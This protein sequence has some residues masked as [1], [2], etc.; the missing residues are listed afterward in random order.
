MGIEAP[1]QTERLCVQ[2]D[3]KMFAWSQA[4]NEK[5]IVSFANML[6]CETL[7]FPDGVDVPE[8]LEDKASSTGG[9]SVGNER[10]DAR[11]PSMVLGLAAVAATVAARRRSRRR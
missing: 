7:H 8:Q 1:T 3:G 9:C 5:Q 6:E 2:D 4:D 10:R 11:A